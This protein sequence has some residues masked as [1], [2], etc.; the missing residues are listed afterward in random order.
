MAHGKKT[1]EGRSERLKLLS[2]FFS[3]TY[4]LFENAANSYLRR[5][6][7]LDDIVDALVAAVTAK[8]GYG[9][10]LTIPERPGTDAEGLPME[11]VFW[12]P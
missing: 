10:Y 8:M 6:V 7:A 5:Q 2:Q 9:C 12:P 11:M 1:S 3:P 4:S